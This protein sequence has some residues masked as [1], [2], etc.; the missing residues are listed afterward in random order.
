MLFLIKKGVIMFFRF[1]LVCFFFF[2]SNTIAKNIR[3]N[4]TKILYFE[5]RERMN[6]STY[7]FITSDRLI[8]FSY[9]HIPA[10]RA[11]SSRVGL[12]RVHA[13]TVSHTPRNFSLGTYKDFFYAVPLGLLKSHLSVCQQRAAIT[14]ES[15]KIIPKI[16]EI[17]SEQKITFSKSDAINHYFMVSSIDYPIFKIIEGDDNKISVQL[18]Q[19]HPVKNDEMKTSSFEYTLEQSSKARIG[20]IQVGE[21]A[22]KLFAD[23]CSRA[24]SGRNEL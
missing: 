10:H 20:N 24:A 15:R 22:E 17:L 5:V 16:E 2:S 7:Y 12:G 13:K 4:G 3:G 18:F 23:F 6:S 19:I 8:A 21:Q 11:S 1:L 14:E 9:E